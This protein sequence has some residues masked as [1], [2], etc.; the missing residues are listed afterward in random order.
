M[1]LE[2]ARTRGEGVEEEELL[3]GAHEAMVPLLGFFDTML[4]LC[5]SLHRPQS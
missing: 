5:Q 1:W 4:I 2:K 3:L